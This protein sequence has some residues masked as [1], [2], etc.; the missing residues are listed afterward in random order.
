VIGISTSPSARTSQ[1][2]LSLISRTGQEDGL[3]LQLSVCVCVKTVEVLWSHRIIPSPPL[4]LP[5]PQFLDSSI[6]QLLS[7]IFHSSSLPASLHFQDLSPVGVLPS[8]NCQ[9]VTHLA[10][11]AAADGLPSSPCFHSLGSNQKTL[12]IAILTLTW[13]YR[14]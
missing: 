14:T 7:S 5:V 10:L 3:I 11:I 9:L 6:P 2:S 12:A 8:Q 1:A 4:L 13:Y